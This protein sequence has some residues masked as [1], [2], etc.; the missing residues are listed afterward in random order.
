M[1]SREIGIEKKRER[2]RT[3]VV[4]MQIMYIA[5][6]LKAAKAWAEHYQ[7]PKKKNVSE[8]LRANVGAVAQW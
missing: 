2:V 6:E 3:Y 7:L 1:D 8:K 4:L 5:N